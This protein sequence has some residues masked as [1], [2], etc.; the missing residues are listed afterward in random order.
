MIG[1]VRRQVPADEPGPPV[2]RTCFIDA[3]SWWT[4]TFATLAATL[5]VRRGR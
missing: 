5:I 4:A 2:I 3:F 1:E